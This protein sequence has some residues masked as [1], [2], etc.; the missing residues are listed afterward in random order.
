LDG[1]L[2]HEKAT[3]KNAFMRYLRAVFNWGVKRDYLT[4]NPIDKLDFEEV[5]KGDTEIFES[6]IVQ[7]LLQD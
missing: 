6:K 7:A 1:L 3:V 4:E 5:V 2:K